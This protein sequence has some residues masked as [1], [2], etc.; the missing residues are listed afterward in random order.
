MSKIQLERL[1]NDLSELKTYI[2]K[3]KK[4]G[5]KDLVS[6]LKRKQEFLSTTIAEAS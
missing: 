3:V 6:K 1:Q 5:N 4:K 2:E